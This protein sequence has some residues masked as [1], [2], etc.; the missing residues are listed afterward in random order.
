MGSM[1]S[2]IEMIPGL[3]GNLPDQGSAQEKEM[4]K[5][6]AIIL[7]M[8]AKERR[9]HL[10]IGPSRRKRIAKGSGTAVFDVNRLLK[11]FQKSRNMMKKMAKN[12]D[13]QANMMS[14][15]GV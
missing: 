9:N 4:R 14:R 5:N 12:K 6:E 10:I 8:T 3:K 11:Q 1:Q 15:L 2:L 13:Y 7:S